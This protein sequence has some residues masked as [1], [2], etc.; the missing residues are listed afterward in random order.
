MG[1]FTVKIYYQVHT[2]Y[3]C[4][5]QDT[6]KQETGSPHISFQLVSVYSQIVPS[7]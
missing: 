1:F 4:Q 3:V 7:N 6:N 5:L 2:V